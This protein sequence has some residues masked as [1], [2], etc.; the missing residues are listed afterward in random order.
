MASDEPAADPSEKPADPGLFGDGMPFAAAP[1]PALVMT[2]DGGVR[3][4]NAA[5]DRLRTCLGA[6]LP[7]RLVAA[8]RTGVQGRPAELERL[9]LTAHAAETGPVRRS[10]RV[11]VLP[12]A[13]NAACLVL[14]HE[15]TAHQQQ[16]A[17]LRAH[18][19]RCCGLVAV[20]GD[21]FGWETDAHG[22]LTYVSHPPPWGGPGANADGGD[23]VAWTDDPTAA[24]RVFQATAPIQGVHLTLI[25][26]QGARVP[27]RVD[28]APIRDDDGTWLGARGVCREV[29]EPSRDEATLHRVR[30]R[31]QL[32]Y[33]I[34][35][36]T[37]EESG[38]QAILDTAARGILPALDAE[39]AAVYRDTGDGP[40]LVA[41]AGTVIPETAV[42][43]ALD[44]IGVAQSEVAT[45]EAGVD[46][47]TVP[48]RHGGQV[49]GALC[50]WHTHGLG[51]WDADERALAAELAAQIAMANTQLKRE[52]EWRRLSESDSLTGLVNRRAFLSY[53]TE[54]LRSAAAPGALLYVDLDNF[55]R[56]NDVRGHIA[57]DD[58]LMAVARLLR[59][60]TRDNDV[61]A[62]LGGDEFALFMTEITGETAMRRA[63]SLAQTAREA[64]TDE[65][66]DPAHPLG[67]SIGVAT[68]DPAR[69]ES[70]TDLLERADAA[71]YRAKRA[72]KSDVAMADA[73][74]APTESG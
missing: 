45:A 19:A 62:R 27:Y 54:H 32:L 3:A 52:T 7:D 15:I 48:T 49:N 44:R 59:A 17:A 66:G 14:A 11:A 56:V 34:L 42:S 64:L 9:D 4:A 47:L 38:P 51:H 41:H 68:T 22:R 8:L 74:G 31:E 10:F 40:V 43:D 70:A 21:G 69:R 57:G 25:E 33:A 36:V 20:I 46:V 24:R 13:L 18:A 6:A 55:K 12:W 61:A 29:A 67:T 16:W 39:G 71:M 63:A 72:G 58:V 26:A 73:P 30:Q 35:R 23:P 60:H 1:W 28:A 2:A 53:L 5:A 65:S 37:R 50:L